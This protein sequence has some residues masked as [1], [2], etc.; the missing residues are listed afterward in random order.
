MTLNNDNL[1]RIDK[2]KC[3]KDCCK[4]NQWDMKTYK[5]TNFNKKIKPDD[6][7]GSNLSCNFGEGSGC[8]C[9]TSKTLQ[10][11]TNRY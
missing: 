7:I 4:F 1:V 5:N 9:T 2:L 3:S 10:S 6:Y 11:L 8:V